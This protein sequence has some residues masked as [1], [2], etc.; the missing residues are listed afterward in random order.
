[1]TALAC[2]TTTMPNVRSC[3][4]RGEHVDSCQLE[5]CAGCRPRPARFGILC[6]ACWFDLEHAVADYSAA[7][8]RLAA[9]GGHAVSPERGST[10]AGP[11]LPLTGL[12]VDLDALDRAH[13]AIRFP[14]SLWVSDEAGARAAVTF[15]RLVHRLLPRHPW[16]EDPHNLPRTRCPNCS[17]LTLRELPPTHK[18]DARTVACKN[19]GHTLDQSA[20]EALAAIEAQCCRRCRDTTCNDPECR[21]HRVAAVPEWMQSTRGEFVPYDP[22]NPEHRALRDAS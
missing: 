2:I 4:V 18:G 5:T 1:M 16:K 15:T 3:T 12:E 21:C 19:C 17:L 13:S 7:R 22:T 11:R 9:A 8:P 10:H 14:L 6:A 20:Y